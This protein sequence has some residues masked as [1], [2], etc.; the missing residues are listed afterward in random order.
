VS[1]PVR[2]VVAVVVAM[3]LLGGSL[4]A[5]ERARDAHAA[6]RL[7]DTTADLADTADRLADRNDATRAGDA[8]VVVWLRVPAGG[9]FRVVD[10]HLGWRIDGGPWHRRHLA[11]AVDS[12][13]GRLRLAPGRHRLRLTLHRHGGRRA[14]V[15]VSR[16][17]GG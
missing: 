12:R 9:S 14:V 2:V 1:G 7:D 5:V 11:V 16:A 6:T 13:T 4:A 3:A 8:R 17:P 10:G 15:V